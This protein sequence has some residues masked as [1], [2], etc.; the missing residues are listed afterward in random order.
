[1][2][3][4]TLSLYIHIPY[5]IHKCPYCDFNS[6][7]ITTDFDEDRYLAALLRDFTN[8]LRFVQNTII[9][10][11]FIGGGTPNTI[12]PTGIKYL[13][14]SLKKITP[15]SA[16]AEISMEFNPG[17]KEANLLK[18]YKEAGINRLSIGVQ[19]F[20]DAKLTTLERIHTA[21]Q[22]INTI[23]T[24]Q[25]YFTNINIDLMFA[26]PQ[27]TLQEALDDLK[28]AVSY[29]P[30]HISWYQLTIE[31][32]TRFYKAPPKNLPDDDAMY[33]IYQ[34]GRKFLQEHGY[35]QYEVS[36]YSKE[37]K[38]CKHNLN[39]WHYGDYLGIGAG[40]HGKVTLPSGVYRTVKYS[41]PNKYLL[42]DYLSDF[43]KI[44]EQDIPFEYFLNTLRLFTKIPKSDFMLRTN[45]PLE[46]IEDKLVAL[47]HKGFLV[48]DKNYIELTE[49]GHL[50][51]NDV[52]LE[53]ME[54]EE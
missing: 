17:A 13:L 54:D 53:F 15:I 44:P 26:L 5:C 27:Q 4:N 11:I 1:M 52:L 2:S 34:A 36:A 21:Q 25:Q 3:N 24:A 8:D 49:Q 51:L 16:T 19:S 39:Y 48:D 38:Q 40:A 28:Q 30:N 23:A 45:L 9:D 42:G 29:A 12:S 41:S 22:A 6:H 20:N 10:T 46:V 33:D 37:K 18:D 7:N 31:P 43:T 50:L 32:N 35:V 14:S 47:V